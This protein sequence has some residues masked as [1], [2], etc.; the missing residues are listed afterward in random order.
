MGKVLLNSAKCAYLVDSFCLSSAYMLL[1]LLLYWDAVQ[2]HVC[3]MQ[4]KDKFDKNM[5]AV[6][7]SG[8]LPSHGMK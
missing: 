1:A 6:F 5:C 4:R 7:T 2:L 3:M 8:C